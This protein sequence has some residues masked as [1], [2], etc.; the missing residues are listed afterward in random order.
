MNIV[1]LTFNGKSYRFTSPG[2]W[3]ALS[4]QQFLIAAQLL[5]AEYPQEKLTLGLLAVREFLQIPKAIFNALDTEQLATLL[6]TLGFLHQTPGPLT[7]KI[8]RIGKTFGPADKL[9]NLTFGEFMFAEKYVQ[10]RQLDYLVATLYRPQAADGNKG[11]TREAFNTNSIEDRLPAA[12]AQ[13]RA[14]KQAVLL[15]YCS[16]RA[17]MAKLFPNVFPEPD[18]TDNKKATADHTWLDIALDLA[19]KEPALGD[20]EKLQQ[21]NL[22]LVLRLLDKVMAEHQEQIREMEKHRRRKR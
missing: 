17:A 4:E 3:E 11:D 9:A 5:N 10:S 2:S 19:R 16:I 13:S 21:Q 22:Y 14:L 7:W 6:D 8:R 1:T 12:V 15:N 20:F 18:G